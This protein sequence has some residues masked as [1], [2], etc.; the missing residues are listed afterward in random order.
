MF[1]RRHHP[2]S[3]SVISLL[4]GATDLVTKPGH[5]NTR[6]RLRPGICRVYTGVA[7][8][9]RAESSVVILAIVPVLVRINRR[10]LRVPANSPVVLTDNTANQI[11][12][13]VRHGCRLPL[14]PHSN[15]A[16]F[17]DTH[18]GTNVY[19]RPAR[20][21]GHKCWVEAIPV[22]GIHWVCPG[23]G[24]AKHH[25]PELWAHL[26]A[27]GSP[28]TLLQRLVETAPTVGAPRPQYDH[29][30]VASS[31]ELNARLHVA[32]TAI[33]KSAL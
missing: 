25:L 3:A 31:P 22:S 28:P 14:I 7:S 30:T 21:S 9:A 6:Q 1:G 24:L 10:I 29:N 4:I 16:S 20:R 2:P 5:N 27:R 26:R 8:I 17:L 33:S 18:G 11:T 13:T 12:V 19:F 23:C 32:L 15:L